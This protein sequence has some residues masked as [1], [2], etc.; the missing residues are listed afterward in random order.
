MYIYMQLMPDLP[1]IDILGKWFKAECTQRGIQ[2][3]QLY[4]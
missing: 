2:L 3:P 1:E 4:Y